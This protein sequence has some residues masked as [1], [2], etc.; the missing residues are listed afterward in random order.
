VVPYGLR[1]SFLS[2]RGDRE[3]RNHAPPTGTLLK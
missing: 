2:R 3:A 1:L